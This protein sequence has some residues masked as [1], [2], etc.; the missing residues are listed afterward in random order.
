MVKITEWGR[1][2]HRPLVSGNSAES[3]TAFEPSSI[4]KR[5]L[6]FGESLT[7][8]VDSAIGI[9]ASDSRQTVLWCDVYDPPK[10]IIA[11]MPVFAAMMG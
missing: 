6:D 4:A 5:A 9:D 8:R 10:S 2:R 1:R 11:K 3:I 7:R